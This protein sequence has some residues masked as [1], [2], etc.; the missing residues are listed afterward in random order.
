MNPEIAVRKGQVVTAV[1]LGGVWLRLVQ[2]RLGDSAE[3]LSAGRQGPVLLAAKAKKIEGFSEEQTATAL[4]ELA[5][6]LPVRTEQVLGLVSTGEIL[7]RYLRLPSADPEELRAMARY[8]LEGLLPFP[9]QECSTSVR[10]LGPA[11]EAVRVLAAAVHRPVVE[12]F[13]RVCGKAGLSLNGIATSAEAVETWHQLCVP[14][15]G[16]REV[17]VW[18]SAEIGPDGL[19]LAIASE[20]SL[21]YMRQVPAPADLDQMAE[22]I[23]ETL[24]AYTREQVGP[25]VERMILSGNFG[26]F[27]RIPLERLESALEMPVQRLNPTEGGPLKESIRSVLQAV[28]P[29]LTFSDL[30]GAALSPRLLELDLLP[31]ENRLE[32][33]RRIFSK[34]LR[35]TTGFVLFGLALLLVWVGVRVGV[36]WWR[37][38]ETRSEM[39]AVKPQAE[40]VQALLSSIRTVAGSRAEYA[41]LMECMAAGLTQAQPGV[42]LRFLG[43]E[44]D[45]T[46]SVRGWA[47]DL[48]VLTH[49][50]TS[51]REAPLWEEVLLRSAKSEEK[52]EG[53]S[54]VVDFELLLRPVPGRKE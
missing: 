35:R 5:R 48:A 49:Y 44:P 33:A 17:K 18:L 19:D 6:A 39:E 26:E 46:I 3:R 31:V 42:T 24:R 11:G 14:P 13:V 32:R 37:V 15:L 10:V 12:R 21:V 2:A 40:K 43:L 47:P 36:T 9:A 29:E 16:R 50:A 30:L 27:Q 52:G 20:G 34:E 51:L 25:P 22:R 28:Q 1:S 54:P 7:T 23:K 4:K 45:R 53:K 41:F 38:Q 8:Q